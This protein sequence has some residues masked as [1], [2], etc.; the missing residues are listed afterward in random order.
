MLVNE[1]TTNDQIELNVGELADGG[2]VISWNGYNSSTGSYD[3][4]ARVYDANGNPE[5]GELVVNA[6]TANYQYTD[7]DSTENVIGLAG[8]GFVVVWS[9]YSNSLDGSGGGVG[10]ASLTPPAHR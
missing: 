2:Y 10:R 3:I 4:Y 9:D 7:A 6:T 1:T 5:T 8:G